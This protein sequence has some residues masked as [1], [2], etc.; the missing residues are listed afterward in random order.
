MD[1][2]L[3]LTVVFLVLGLISAPFIY[4]YMP[5]EKKEELSKTISILG[6]LIAALSLF[7]AAYTYSDNT[8]R[9]REA[10]VAGERL[11]RELAASSLYREHMKISLENGDL[12]GS[13]EIARNGPPA[14]ESPIENHVKF[15]RY[16]WYVGHALLS[17]ESIFEMF[18]NDPAW[19]DTFEGFVCDHKRYLSSTA[20][21]IERYPTLQKTLTE[22]L[23]KCPKQP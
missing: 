10:A 5:L 8:R 20:F 13:S 1:T 11:Q 7:W 6:G 2:M 17:F 9:Q 18:P 22:T 16:Q 21:Q 3:I 12:L 14:K 23:E 19:K 15:E 4:F